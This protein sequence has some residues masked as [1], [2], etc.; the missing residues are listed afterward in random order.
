MRFFFVCILLVVA[1]SIC[2]GVDL[3]DKVVA[4]VDNDPILA[5][6][7]EAYM[8]FL[9][10]Q[11][12]RRLTADEEE[13]LRAQILQELID[14]RVLLFRA[15]KDTIEVEDREVEQEL[16]ARI[17]REIEQ[18][19]SVEKLEEIYGRPL[20]QLR[21]DLKERI[22][23]GMMIDRVK[24]AYQQNIRVSRSDVEAF[25]EV[26]RDSVPDL[27]EAVEI[28]HILREPRAS[29][30]AREVARDRAWELYREIRNGRDFEEVAKE[31]SDDPGTADSGGELGET[32][33][34]D[35]V[36]GYEEVAYQLEEGEISE[37]VETEFGFHII[38]LNWRRGEKV[39]SSHILVRLKTG[40]K[41]ESTA[42]AFLD[43]LKALVEAGES[44]ADVARKDSDDE[45]S[46][47]SGGLLG[48][49]EVANMPSDFR[50]AVRGLDIGEVSEPFI[51]EFGGHII[52]V[53][54]GQEK[55]PMSLEKDWDRIEM[56]AKNRKRDEVFKDWIQELRQQVYIDTVV[57]AGGR[58]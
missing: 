22:R 20:R 14:R 40:E 27:E 6:E 39:H 28:R 17:N 21:R 24:W 23:E 38:R 33:R 55:R 34:G 11:E 57:V 1:V 42:L 50:Q 58:R 5:S 15:R 7:V 49:Y 46:A 10:S 26:Y 12:R 25:W 2:V 51:S 43:S 44:F 3:V 54:D 36:P 18:L 16:D 19:G 48:W 37:P 53:I 30:S 8:Q 45:D 52:Q 9:M 32:T 47:P 4:V 35:L 31:S 13:K 29:R 41:D 56:M